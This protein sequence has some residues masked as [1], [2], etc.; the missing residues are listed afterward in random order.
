V[1]LGRIGQSADALN[2]SVELVNTSDNSHIWGAQYQRASSDLIAVQNEISREV[3]RQ[4]SISLTG[5]EERRITTNATENTEAYQLYLK[6]QF[7]WNKRTEEGFRKAVELFQSAIGK[8]PAYALAYVGLANCYALMASYYIL[9][10][11]EAYAKARAAANRAI[12]LDNTLA[13]P[14]VNLA[15]IAMDI[16]RRFDIAERE[17]RRSIELNPNYA[18]AH[19]WYGEFIAAMGR[20]EEGRLEIQ[21]AIAIDP[22]APILYASS[23]WISFS[24]G[25]HQQALA[26]ID[27]ALEIDPRFPRAHSLQA[28]VF[29]DLGRGEEALQSCREAIRFSG[30]G[31]EYRALLGYVSGKLG[32]RED[33]EKILSELLGTSQ[34]E[35]VAPTLLALVYTGLGDK[36]KAFAWL[37]K[38]YEARSGDVVLLNLD[39]A[40]EPLRGDPRYAALTKKVGLPQ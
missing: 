29:T 4:L 1:L 16:D 10:A 26:D 38:A 23:A 21:R 15:A 22:L 27:R 30:D 7:Y 11:S 5:D 17:F 13:E 34:T 39:P 24:M 25:D 40:W 19:H 12:E 3:S 2:V 18:T 14:H 33:A 37:E 8:D 20:K 31:I 9:P 36:D 28:V 35:F 6:G 32:K